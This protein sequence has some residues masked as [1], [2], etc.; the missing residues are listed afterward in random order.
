MVKTAMQ[1]KALVRNMSEGD[2][3]KAQAMIR[4]YAME[5]FLARLALSQYS[6]VFILKGGCLLSA[7]VGS[8]KRS[9]MDI[10]FTVKDIMLNEDTAISVVEEIA[11]TP[12]EDG[13]TFEIKK[14]TAIMTERE[15]AGINIKLNAKL[16]RMYIPFEMDLSFGDIITP[17]EISYTYNMMFEKGKSISLKTYNLETIIAEKLCAMLTF[18][19]VNT[20]MRDF[21][22]LH[23]LF[24]AQDID[25][26]ILPAAFAN[27]CGNKGVTFT[28]SEAKAI[29]S[30]ISSNRTIHRNWERYRNLFSFASDISWAEVMNTA[31]GICEYIYA[32]P[33]RKKTSVR[34]LVSTAKNEQRKDER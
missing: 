2:S 34:S 26:G 23:V 32:E 12:M 1:L 19:T 27:T 9:T 14:V 17:Q 6:D 22:D 21:Y 31:E 13:I 16:D 25:K 10:D 30:D 3:A 5:R 28:Y 29:L 33:Q 18:G 4:N 15:H 11:A 20:R 7:I 8:D 24:I